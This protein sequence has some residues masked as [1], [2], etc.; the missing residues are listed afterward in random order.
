LVE[1]DICEA[2]LERLPLC[3]FT[4]GLLNMPLRGGLLL[5]ISLALLSYDSV[6]AGIADVIYGM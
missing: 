5:V 1:T 6:G 4:Q 2:A 3:I